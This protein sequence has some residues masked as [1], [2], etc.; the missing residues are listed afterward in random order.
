MC[1]PL[2]VTFGEYVAL[3]DCMLGEDGSEEA[4]VRVRV[5]VWVW[6]WV[7]ERGKGGK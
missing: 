2:Q 7:G 5:R 1:E 3:S 6:V 4:R